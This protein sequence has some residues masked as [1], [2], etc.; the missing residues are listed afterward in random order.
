MFAELGQATPTR[1]GMPAAVRG[2]VLTVIPW[3]SFPAVRWV[4]S[5]W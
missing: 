5:G 1:N 3:E 4:R 2:M